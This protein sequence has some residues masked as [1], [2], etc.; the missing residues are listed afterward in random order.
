VYNGSLSANNETLGN[1]REIPINMESSINSPWRKVKHFVPVSFAVVAG[2]LI[3]ACG[4]SSPTSASSTAPAVTLNGVNP[5]LL[6]TVVQIG[7]TQTYMLTVV[8]T[9]SVITWSSSP[10]NVLTIDS[11]GDATGVSNGFATITAVADN[12]QSASLLVQ[13]V[14]VYGGTWAGSVTVVGCTGL[15]GFA[16]NGY[17]SQILGSMQAFTM[18]LTQTNGNVGDV[19]SGTFTK[20]EG[21]N[22]LSGSV[23]DGNLGTGG[24]MGGLTGLLAGVADGVNLSLTLTS[25]N[26]LVTGNNMTGA[27]GANITSPQIPGVASVVYSLT[28]VTLVPVSGS[29][30]SRGGSA[31]GRGSTP[32]TGSPVVQPRHST[33]P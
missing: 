9:T 5:S 20:G 2:L 26:S 18:S 29:A 19:V 28:N 32:S 31:P 4:S 22:T 3:G 33:K 11:S 1:R 10:T 17:C 8:P 30:L 23:A 24:D 13:V 21:G 7:Q 15:V 12:G 6:D 25:W 14:P 16:A 27:W